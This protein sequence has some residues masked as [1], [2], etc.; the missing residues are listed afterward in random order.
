MATT[1]DE[2]TQKPQKPVPEAELTWLAVRTFQ[3]REQEV[4]DFLKRQG[5]NPF[6]PMMYE[7]KVKHTKAGDQTHV[8]LKPAIHNYLFIP[9][10]KSDELIDAALRESQ[11]PY[12]II[13]RVENKSYYIVSDKE[14]RVFRMFSDPDF[15]G[16]VFLNEK[17][18]EA[19]PGKIV[20]VV[21]GQFEGM[22]GKLHRINNQYFFIKNIANIGV[23]VRISRWYCKVI[24]DQDTK[25]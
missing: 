22:V 24:E 13:R 1:I 15:K 14:M 7:K 8:V 12:Y 17:E 5:L 4:C 20:R 23:M 18:A 11:Y 6:V 21:H 16:S 2:T 9:R 25:Q 3:C 10:T 19:K